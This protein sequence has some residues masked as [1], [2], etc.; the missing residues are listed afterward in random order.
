[1]RKR[2]EKLKMDIFNSSELCELLVDMGRPAEAVPI[3][4]DMEAR[5]G[6]EANTPL[7]NKI[8]MTQAYTQAEDAS[9]KPV[10]FE[11]V[12]YR[13]VAFGSNLRHRIVNE[14]PRSLK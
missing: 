2:F 5:F 9:A 10:R 14:A 4:R 13:W 11:Q 6:A 12:R 7:A 3:Y 1:M 8:G